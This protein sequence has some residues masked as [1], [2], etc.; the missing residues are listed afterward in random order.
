MDKD[1]LATGA[2]QKPF[3]WH[4]PA[5]PLTRKAVVDPLG[6]KF[7]QIWYLEKAIQVSRSVAR[8]LFPDGKHFATCF[9]VATDLIMTNHHVFGSSYET[10]GV[11][12]QF[13]YR[14][15]LDGDLE[16]VEDY[17]CDPSTFFTSQEFDYSV[18]KLDRPAAERWGY[19]PMR[20]GQ[21]TPRESHIAIIQHPEGEPLQ[22]AMRDNSLVYDD[23]NT[24]EYLTSTEYGSSGSP[25]FND[26]W[27]LIA[28]HSQRV[29][30]PSITDRKVWYR[31]RGIK[32]N[33][34]L[35]NKALAALIPK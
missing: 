2:P 25:V 26:Y 22:V 11:R 21:A 33:A 13:N 4:G 12:I 14:E 6:G 17:G 28:L 8:V 32:M 27:Q 10:E 18:V 31:N 24:V 5:D 1:W 35:Q 16:E 34:I 20:Q 3:A 9:L 23:A 15:N 29:Q 19:L 7:K 30:D